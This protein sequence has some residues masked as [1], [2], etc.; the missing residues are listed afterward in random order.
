M[1]ESQKRHLRKIG[2]VFALEAE[3]QGLERVLSQ[4]YTMLHSIKNQLSWKIGNVELITTIS[5]IG[6]KKCA[7]ATESLIHSGAKCIIC[8]GYSAAL[9]PDANVGDVVVANRIHLLDK[10]AQILNND[11]RLLKVVPPSD[12]F[13]FRIRWCDF[14]CCDS[15]VCSSLEKTQ[16]HRATSAS[17]LDMES[18]GA[19]EVCHNAGIPFLAI[20]SISDTSDQDLPP[21]VCTL[22]SLESKTQQILYALSQPGI[23]LK[24]MRLSKQTKTASQNLGDVLGLILL[25]LI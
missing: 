15:I 19:A 1:S 24:L 20:R 17:A 22:A 21:E 7:D 18:Y 8:A 12:T 25:R 6:R 16:I 11:P 10:S 9:S 5:G 3:K 4:S 23:W 14:I 2:I 13:E